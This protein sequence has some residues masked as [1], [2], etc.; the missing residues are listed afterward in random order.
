MT[1]SIKMM[2]AGAGLVVKKIG[3]GGAGEATVIAAKPGVKYVLSQNWD[4]NSDHKGAPKKIVAQRVGNNLQIAI[5]A[6]NAAN[7]DITIADYFLYAPAPISGIG[8]TGEVFDYGAL[9][10]NTIS[11]APV[12]AEVVL[13]ASG[14]SLA[15]LSDMRTLPSGPFPALGTAGQLALA[16]GGLLVLGAATAGSGSSS[17][18]GNPAANA[19]QAVISA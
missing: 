13:A 9:D 14:E 4:A 12:T 1:Y 17:G 8:P 5:D 15:T 10:A 18:E 3:D 19:A 2:K 7:P 16:A 6:V 11:G